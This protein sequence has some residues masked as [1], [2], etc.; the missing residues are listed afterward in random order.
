MIFLLVQNPVNWINF[1]A[2]IGSVFVSLAAIY[3][4][5]KN[6]QKILA[7]SDINIQNTLAA[8]SLNTDKTIKS[9][10]IEERKNEIYKSLNDFYGPLYQLRQKS[11]LLYDKFKVNKTPNTPDSRF[12]TLLYL[13][14]E[15]GPDK[16]SDNEK[17]LLHEIIKIGEQCE[18]L[19]H[20]K[21]GLIDDENLRSEWFP[22]ATKHF[23][24]L[25]LAHSGKLKG[26]VD[27]F[28][29]SMFPIEIDELIEKRINDLRIELKNLG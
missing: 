8:N 14:T 21:A 24:I 6:S 9:K 28:S 12:S 4:A 13:L 29:D 16:L 22:K 20:D 2:S 26:Q 1:T 3:F 10:R 19:I 11:K 7:S 5:F 25:R 15:G 17:E 27:L 23:L 18:K